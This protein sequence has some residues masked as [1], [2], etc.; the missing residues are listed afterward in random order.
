M[1]I[2]TKLVLPALYVFF[3]Q[4]YIFIC[5]FRQVRAAQK[6]FETIPILSKTIHLPFKKS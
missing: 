5:S 4:N 2:W 6:Y 1:K 3:E